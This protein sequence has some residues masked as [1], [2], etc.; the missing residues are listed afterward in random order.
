VSIGELWAEMDMVDA[1]SHGGTSAVN[2]PR[3]VHHKRRSMP[4]VK[5]TGERTSHTDMGAL[6]DDTPG[7]TNA[8]PR[9]RKSG[10]GKYSM[11]NKAV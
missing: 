7:P 3:N 6:L 8:L 11:K 1:I 9:G 5:I 4:L 2:I 10:R